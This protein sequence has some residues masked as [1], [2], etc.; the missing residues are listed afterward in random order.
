M[1][2]Q[3]QNEGMK[4][5]KDVDVWH[6][7]W[8]LILRAKA[9]GRRAP[10]DAA[11]HAQPLLASRPALKLAE[12]V[13]YVLFCLRTGGLIDGILGATSLV[14]DV[15][16]P[17][18]VLLSLRDSP[19]LQWKHSSTAC[20]H[21]RTLADFMHSTLDQAAVQRALCMAS[22]CPAGGVVTLTVCNTPALSRKCYT[23]FLLY[24]PQ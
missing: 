21:R 2:I 22:L 13:S 12:E 3:A 20:L 8:K 1:Q 19:W 24:G 14:V 11:G 9:L 23:S 7:A 17:H 15:N 18:V 4:G 16:A 5:D 6:S 10:D